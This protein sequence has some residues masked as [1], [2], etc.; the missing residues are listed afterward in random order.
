[1]FMHLA[2]Q[3]PTVRV[4]DRSKHIIVIYNLFFFNELLC[5]M[6]AEDVDDWWDDA[7]QYWHIDDVKEILTE[8]RD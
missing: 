3:R 7:G 1:M 6:Y 8:W 2:K 5:R 4:S